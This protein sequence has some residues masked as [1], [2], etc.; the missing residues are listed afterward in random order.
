MRVILA[1]RNPHKLREMRA[2]LAMPGLELV[3]LEDVPGA[4]DVEEDG[5]SFQENAVKKAL[6]IALAT[7]QWVLAD[8]SGLEVEA[9]H[10]APGVKSARFAGEPVNYEANNRKLLGLLEGAPNRRARFRCVLALSSPG[11]RVQIV[12]GVCEGTITEAPRGERGFGY[13]PVFVP[14]GD[15]RTFAEMEPEEK[16]QRSHR[17]RAAAQARAKWGRFLAGEP[18]EWSSFRP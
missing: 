6:V 9:L 12:E 15:T 17:A 13:D 10:G 1:T 2:L 14:D 11:G 5:A 4:P 8:D 18:E 3:G 7:R 16:N